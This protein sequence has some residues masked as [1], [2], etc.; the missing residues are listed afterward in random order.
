MALVR[1][2]DSYIIIIEEVE[3]GKGQIDRHMRKMQMRI[4]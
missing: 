3:Y 1:R 2:I 4:S